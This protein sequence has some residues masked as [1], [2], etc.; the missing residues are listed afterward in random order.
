[1]KE[2]N[3]EIRILSTPS[4]VWETLMDLEN[5]SK[6]N[7][8]VNNIHGKLSIGGQL[9]ITMSDSKGNPAKKYKAVITE[10]KKNERFS[11]I[12]TM[13]GKFIF[14]AER[15]IELKTT[16]KETILIQREVYTGVMVTLFWKKLS[17]DALGILES[18]NKALKQE[19]EK[20]K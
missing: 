20:E 7:P 17:T 2:I 19:I 12:A 11:F 13:M 4:K 16:N 15:T 10:L 9:S 5:W 3:T 6:W 14:S 8:V 1:M 18:M